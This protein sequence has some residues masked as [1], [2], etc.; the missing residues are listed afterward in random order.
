MYTAKE[1]RFKKY[2]EEQ[3]EG[4][5]IKYILLYTFVG[6]FMLSLIISVL[7]L[8]FY[9]LYPGTPAFWIVPGTAVLL[10]LIYA[11]VSWRYNEEKWKKLSSEA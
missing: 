10:S 8:L 11:F 5:K 7:L 6:T 3:R 4:G 9:N 1:L 2:W